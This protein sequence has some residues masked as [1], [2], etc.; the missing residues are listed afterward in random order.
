MK[1]IWVLNYDGNISTEGY[2]SEDKAFKRLESQGYEQV[3][4]YLFKNGDKYCTLK[5]ITVK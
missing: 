2:D 1:Y 4:G 5:C 3:V